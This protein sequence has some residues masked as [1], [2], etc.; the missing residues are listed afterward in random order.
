MFLNNNYKVYGMITIK[1]DLF[2]TT[3]GSVG[4]ASNGISRFVWAFLTDKYGYKKM[5]T[6]MLVIQ[7]CV[8]GTFTLISDSKPLYLVWYMISMSCQG[9][10]STMQPTITA[11]VFG[12]K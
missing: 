4:A 12:P 6:C 7:A 9:G 8:A 11:K 1:D 3:V 2:L 10:L 5:F